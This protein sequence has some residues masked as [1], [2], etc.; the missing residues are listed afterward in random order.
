[1]KPPCANN[2]S[3]V[4]IETNPYYSHIVRNKEPEH[5]DFHRSS[6][7]S[8]SEGT[9]SNDAAAS[10]LSN[11]LVDG[12]KQVIVIDDDH[13][14]A[15]TVKTCL[16]GYKIIDNAS[17]ETQVIEVTMYTDPVKA[18]V[19]FRPYYY[20]LLLVD[21]NMPTINGYELVEKIARLDLNLKVCFMSSGEINYEAIREIH[22]PSRSFGCFIKKPASSDYLIN[23]V[24]QEL[25]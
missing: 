24:V 10:K 13:D 19:D 12:N 5:P 22:H 14:S 7:L 16:E 8:N 3:S 18:L 17:S 11:R 23:R 15:L 4:D 2:S 1:L 9:V 25:F 21:I 20:D 6:V